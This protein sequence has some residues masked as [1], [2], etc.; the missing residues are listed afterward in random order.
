M[1]LVVLFGAII[2]GYLLVYKPEIVAIILF[3][4]VI[5]NI[6]V[7]LPGMPINTRALITLALFAR[8]MLDR[9][10]R[11]TYP[12]FFS[13]PNTTLFIIFMLYML[14]I[15]YAH[16]LFS[17]DLVKVVLSTTLAAYCVYHYFFVVGN[18]RIIKAAIITSGL[19]CFADLAYTYAFY[20][21]FPVRRVVDEVMG[22]NAEVDPNNILIADFNHNFF[23]QVCGMCFIYV[24]S[25]FIKN[26]D[27]PR[28]QI[29]LI[30]VMLMGI[31][32]STSRSA[33]MS[34]VLVAIFMVFTSMK[35]IEQRKKIFRITWFL[36]GAVLVGGLLFST[37]GMYLKLDSRFV[38]EVVNRLAEEP[39]AIIQRALGQKYDVQS[40]GSMDWREEAASD[41]Y[42]A[43]AKLELHEQMFGI[44]EGGFIARNLGHGLNTHNGV[45]LIMIQYGLVGFLIYCMIMFNSLW[46][47]LR[48]KNVTPSFGV[49]IFIMIY[50]AGQNNELTS[51]STFLFVFH[52]V[53]ENKK[54]Y[55]WR[56]RIMA[57]VR[58]MRN[59]AAKITRTNLVKV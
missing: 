55:E 40:L 5:D 30:P 33:L 59:A 15:S 16:D 32:M 27:A 1:I 36:T 38:D 37:I 31:L 24:F 26:K 29:L 35:Y 34:A 44:G 2:M 18:A 19:I 20:G 11:N 9:E 39:I 3:T 14:F 43:Y 58:R 8:I 28:W 52:L 6:N 45:L 7:D 13:V 49:V 25:D 57:P 47:A 17:F 42:A 4:L 41:A 54:E 21:S 46:Q 51:A 23:G 12:A 50:A 53:A 56:K 48:M 10:H 22:K